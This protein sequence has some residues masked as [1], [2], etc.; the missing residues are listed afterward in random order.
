MHGTADSVFSACNAGADGYLAKD[1]DS[2]EFFLAIESVLKGHQYV[3]P[4]VARVVV[5]GYLAT[6]RQTGPLALLNTLTPREK[7]VL[8]LIAQ[9]KRNKELSQLLDLS[10]KTVE[11]HRSNIIKKLRIENPKILPA[12]ARN[13]VIFFELAE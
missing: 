8:G 2:Q 5:N 13:A 7:E 1:A 6:R 12:L 4:N 9:G 10:T 11:K 3:C